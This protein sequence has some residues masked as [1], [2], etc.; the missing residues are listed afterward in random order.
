MPQNYPTPSVVLAR[1][2]VGLLVLGGLIWGV[3]AGVSAVISFVNN[4]F[5]PGASSTLVAG[6]DCQ[7]Q[8]ISI[9]A[10]VGTSASEVQGAFNPGDAP[11]FWF[12]VT[13]TGPVDCKF[14][15]GSSVTFYSVT[16]GSDNVWNSKDCKGVT[17][18]DFVTTLKP[19]QPVSNPPTDWQ[20]VRSSGSGCSIADGQ[21]TVPADGA[22]YVLHAEVNGVISANTTQFVLN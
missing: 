8:Q 20:R 21:M 16:S 5:N 4:L 10:H 1:R 19:N 18:E 2:I 7:P 11:Y 22:S 6:A 14:N 9:E 12:T 13:N 15:V 17:R 3:V